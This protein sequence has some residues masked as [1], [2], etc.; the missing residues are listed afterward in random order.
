MQGTVFGLEELFKIFK[1]SEESWFSA[2]KNYFRVELVLWIRIH[3][4]FPD[5]GS[6]L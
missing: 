2:E 3:E 1:F 4:L 5:L 6:N